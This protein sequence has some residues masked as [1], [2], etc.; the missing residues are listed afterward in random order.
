MG[1]MLSVITGIVMFVIGCIVGYTCHP[2]DTLI[3]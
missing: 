2:N 3:K 1:T